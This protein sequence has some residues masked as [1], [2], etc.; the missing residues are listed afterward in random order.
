M[1]PIETEKTLTHII[2]INLNVE[3]LA[4]NILDV[5]GKVLNLLRRTLLIVKFRDITRKVICIFI[6]QYIF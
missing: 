1:L 5:I 3:A 2:D 4:Q 6:N